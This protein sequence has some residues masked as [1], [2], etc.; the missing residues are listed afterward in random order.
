MHVYRVKV[1]HGRWVDL[2]NHVIYAK[3][4]MEKILV[5]IAKNV[6]RVWYK[7]EPVIHV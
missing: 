6:N 4:A 5:I 3:L 1:I 2:L 7:M